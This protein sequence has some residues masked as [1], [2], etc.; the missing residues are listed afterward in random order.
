MKQWAIQRRTFLDG[1]Y[2]RIDETF[3]DEA[4][5]RAELAIQIGPRGQY[6][7]DRSPSG[8]RLVVREIGEWEVVDDD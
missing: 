1:D 6:R 4:A 8:A 2:D 3:Y 5:A 7:A